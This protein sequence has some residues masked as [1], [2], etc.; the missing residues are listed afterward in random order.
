MALIDSHSGTAN[1]F[2]LR[3]NPRFV[4]TS[5]LRAQAQKPLRSIP[6]PSGAPKNTL[7]RF[8][9]P[10]QGYERPFGHTHRLSVASHRSFVGIP[11]LFLEGNTAFCNSHRIIVATL[12]LSVAIPRSFGRVNERLFN[13]HRISVAS[14]AT[15]VALTRL[16]VRRHRTSVRA[17]KLIGAFPHCLRNIIPSKQHTYVESRIPTP[18]R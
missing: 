7:I 9:F 2:S 11:K 1:R 15:F 4:Q 3:G 18:W 17:Q 10:F 5:N 8:D 6:N 16:S 13:S 12:L 14:H